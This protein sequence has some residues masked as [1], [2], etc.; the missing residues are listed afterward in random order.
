MYHCRPHQ[1][2][3][4]GC[5]EHPLQPFGLPEICHWEPRGLHEK[6]KG[7]VRKLKLYTSKTFSSQLDKTMHP[8]I[9]SCEI[10]IC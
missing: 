6:I 8:T 3:C 9:F 7:N 1:I 5:P 4:P 2:Q 10:L